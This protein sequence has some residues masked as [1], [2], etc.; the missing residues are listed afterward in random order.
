MM[1]NERRLPQMFLI[2]DTKA[3]YYKPP[4]LFRTKGDAI[5]WFTSMVSSN[6]NELG[7]NPE[8]FNLFYIGEFDEITGKIIENTAKECVGCGIEFVKNNN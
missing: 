5:R 7:K 8:D 2:Y 4:I 6:D 3:E 1:K